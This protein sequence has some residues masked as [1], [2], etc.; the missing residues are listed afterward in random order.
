M[1]P[2]ENL[3][4]DLDWISGHISGRIWTISIGV[5]AFTLTFIVESTGNPVNPFLRPAQ[6]IGSSVCALVAVLF[7]LLQYLAGYRL[8]VDLLN[9]WRN[10]AS[11]KNRSTTAPRG[12]KF[13]SLATG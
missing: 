2:K 6:V 10:R 4:K 3:I 7:D 9:R 5:M 12:S 11:T 8:S 13:A 1:P